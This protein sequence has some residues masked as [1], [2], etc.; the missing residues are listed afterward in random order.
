M[1]VFIIAAMTLDGFIAQDVTQISTSWTSQEDKKF[2]RDRTKQAGVIVM[3]AKT[4]QTIGRPLPDRLNIVYS[5]NPT[6]SITPAE[7]LQVTSAA[8][9]DLIAELA[10]KG[11]T[12]IAICGGA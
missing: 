3:G 10:A 2:F 5:K 8:P 9:A 4:Y 7:N 6:P 1:N 12:E 11:H